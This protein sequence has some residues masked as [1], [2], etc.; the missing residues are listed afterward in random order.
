MAEQQAATSSAAAPT[1]PAD[2]D[3]LLT[4]TPDTAQT[5]GQAPADSVTPPA[6]P[7]TG[8]AGT[9]GGEGQPQGAPESYEFKFPEG[10][11]PDK[12]MLAQ[13]EPI[14]KELG[15]TQEAAQRLVDLSA[16]QLAKVT[17]AQRQA[18][19]QQTVQWVDQVKADKEIG[20][21][22]LQERLGVAKKALEAFGSPELTQ[23]LNA[24][25]LGNHPELIRAFYRAGKAISEDSVITGGQGGNSAPKSAEQILYPNMQ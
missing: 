22:Q 20:G 7:A 14:A 3:T 13:F 2:G 23:Y 18:F 5:G 17:E 8:G 21:D 16:Q 25:G 10:V 19:E 1:G 9:E 24:T 15:L 6:D 12:E 4:T 11:E